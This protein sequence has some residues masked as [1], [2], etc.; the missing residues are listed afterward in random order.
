[1]KRLFILLPLVL[2]SGCEPYNYAEDEK[3]VHVLKTDVVC[4]VI[5]KQEYSISTSPD[6]GVKT[7]S[8]CIFLKE[9]YETYS[10]EQKARQQ[11]LKEML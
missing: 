6:I 2:F 8:K 3:Y 1:M 5:S 7:I 9:E 11:E 10:P 4:K